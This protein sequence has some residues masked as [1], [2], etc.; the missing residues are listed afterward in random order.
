MRRIIVPIVTAV[1]LLVV[2]SPAAAV[3]TRGPCTG[4]A[5]FSDGTVLDAAQPLSEV[6]EVPPE[7][8]VTYE[9]SENRPQLEQPTPHSGSITVALP[10]GSWTVATWSGEG[11]ETSAGGEYS[12]EVPEIVPRGTGPITVSGFHT[13]DVVNCAATVRVTLAG[14]PGLP[15]LVAA[16][17]TVLGLVALAASGVP[18]QRGRLAGRPVLGIISGLLAGLV[19]GA[20]LFLYGVVG[21]DSTVLAGLPVLGILVGLILAVWGPFGS[22]GGG[23]AGSLPSDEGSEG[24][25][26]G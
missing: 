1:L 10:L 18:K 25:V 20:A 9:G 4:S 19:G 8:T 7:A 6:T 12:Y 11:V 21:L 24:A 14:D 15:A 16:A 22:G 13:H 23:P 3:I 26:E 17:L 5:T 2:A